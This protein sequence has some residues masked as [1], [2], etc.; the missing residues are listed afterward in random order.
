M[1]SVQNSIFY[2]PK[3]KRLHA[4]KAR[5]AFSVEG[6][7]HLTLLNVWNQVG[8]TDWQW[9]DS[10]YSTHWCY[11][12]FIQAKSLR[13]A[14]DV[15][16]QLQGLLERLDLPLKANADA[17]DSVPIQKSFIAG[18]FYHAAVLQGDS[19]YR[20]VKGKTTMFIHPNSCLFKEH[21]SMR[22]VTNRQVCNVP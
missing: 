5:K 4:D 20:S 21:P 15:R 22:T 1:L 16:N 12:N 9:A 6:G 17:S 11:E 10:S 19:S 13:R 8:F 14:R 3:D 7:D 18:Y 2:R